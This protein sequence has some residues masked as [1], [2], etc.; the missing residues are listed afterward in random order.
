MQNTTEIT[1]LRLTERLGRLL[2]G[3][4]YAAL[5]LCCGGGGMVADVYKRQSAGSAAPELW[6]AGHPEAGC[7]SRGSWRYG[8]CTTAFPE[9]GSR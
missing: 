6:S 7:R 3:R 8:C 9:N 4:S 2:E 1:G 5:C